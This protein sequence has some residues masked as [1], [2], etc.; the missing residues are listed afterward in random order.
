MSLV[1]IGNGPQT[2]GFFMTPHARIDDGMLT[3]VYGYVP[4]R[5][6]IFALLPKALKPGA[7]NYVE[8]PVVTEVDTTRL[9]IQCQ[10]TTPLH[11]DGEI[12]TTVAHTIEYQ[13]LPKALRILGK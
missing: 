7:G 8:D 11:A 2:G 4:S 10:P 12:Q 3:F 1:T 13:I 5:R 6:E 9:R